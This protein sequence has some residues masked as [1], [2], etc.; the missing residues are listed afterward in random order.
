MGRFDDLLQMDKTP[1]PL[2]QKEEIREVERQ[3]P[4]RVPVVLKKAPLQSTSEK[5]EEAVLPPE[6]QKQVSE[7]E[8]MDEDMLSSYQA[9][10]IADI[11]SLVRR[12]GK[13]TAFVRLTQE[14]KQELF[15]VVYTHK[16]QGIRTSENEVC[17][18][19]LNF[20]LRDYKESGD[21]SML[22]KVLKAL[23]S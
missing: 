14:E 22:A 10:M 17:R 23:Y 8:R 4:V 7:N 2:S 13:E 19:A 1:A 3:I 20:L 9:S 5:Q 15:D 12:V 6:E 11:R 16:R 18:V 21:E